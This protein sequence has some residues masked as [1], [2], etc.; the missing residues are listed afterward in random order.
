MKINCFKIYLILNHV[1]ICVVFVLIKDITQPTITCRSNLE[2]EAESPSGTVATWDDGDF[3]VGDDI[4]AGSEISIICAPANETMFEIATTVVTCHATDQANNPSED[5][6]F[7]VIVE[8]NNHH[9][10]ICILC[11]LFF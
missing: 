11:F 9:S 1:F 2:L 5:C 6:T 4:S 10:F 3:T 7:N 8:G